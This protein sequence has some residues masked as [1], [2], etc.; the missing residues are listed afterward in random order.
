MD[1]ETY[2]NWVR[3]KEL[4]EAERKT[5]TYYYKR[6]IYVLQNGRDLGPGMPKL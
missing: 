4:L 3:I 1:K 5:D 2:E 6:A